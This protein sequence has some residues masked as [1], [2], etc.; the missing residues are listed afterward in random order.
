MLN[1]VWN[2][3][4]RAFLAFCGGFS[5]SGGAATFEFLYPTGA[6]K[7][8]FR[9]GIKRVAFTANFHLNMFLRGTDRKTMPAGTFYRRFWKILRMDVFFHDVGTIYQ[10]RL[11]LQPAGS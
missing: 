7:H 9:A 4:C 3:S 2:L 1:E 5:G 11:V 8:L 10:K 6:I